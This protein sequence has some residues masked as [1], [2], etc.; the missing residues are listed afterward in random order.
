LPPYIPA[1]WSRHTCARS[2][3]SPY[4]RQMTT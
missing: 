1:R 3:T 2:R 4:R